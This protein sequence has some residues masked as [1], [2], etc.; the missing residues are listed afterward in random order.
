VVK[1]PQLAAGLKFQ[2]TPPLAES[3]ATEAVKFT[4]EVP[5]YTLV[6]VPDSTRATVMGVT[7]LLLVGLPPHAERKRQ[8]TIAK[9]TIESR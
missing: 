7:M 3:L 8:A 6:V 1:V 5:A 9:Q 4:A 2:V